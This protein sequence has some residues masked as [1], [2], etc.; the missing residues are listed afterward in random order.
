LTRKLFL[1]CVFFLLQFSYASAWLFISEVFPNTT[2]DKNLEYIEII[3]TWEEDVD[4]SWYYLQDKSEKKYVFPDEEV[5]K[6][7]E[8]KQ[9]IRPDTKLILNNSNEEIFLYDADEELV[10]E[11]SYTSSVKWEVIINEDIPETVEVPDEEIDQDIPMVWDDITPFLSWIIDSE[12][13]EYQEEILKVEFPAVEWS[14]Q[15]PTYLENKDEQLYFY[16][17]E[18]DRDECKVNLDFRNSFPDDVKESDYRCE[19]DFGFESDESDKCNPNTVTFPEWTFDIKIK[20]YD[21]NTE[22]FVAD[23]GFI[24]ENINK[25]TLFPVIEGDVTESQRELWNQYLEESEQEEFVINEDAM[26]WQEEF[27]WESDIAQEYLAPEIKISLQRPSYVAENLWLYTC[28]ISREECKINFDFRESFSDEL[29]ERDYACK[30]SFWFETDQGNRCNPNTITFPVWT[31]EVSIYIIHEDDKSVFS[32]KKILIQNDWYTDE[33]IPSSRSEV[34]S[35]WINPSVSVSSWVSKKYLAPATID[36]QSGLEYRD[37]KLYCTRD[38][39]R[40]NLKHEKSADYESCVWSFWKWAEYNNGTQNR[41]NPWYITY[42]KWEFKISLQVY[43]KDL[44]SNFRESRINFQSRDMLEESA[45]VWTLETVQDEPE[46]SDTEV[47]SAELKIILQGKISATKIVE[48]N[49]ITCLES[50]KCYIN[51][52]SEWGNNDWKY[53]WDF[54][55]GEVF[56]WKNPKWIWFWEWQYSVLLSQ[57]EI[58]QVFEILVSS[59]KIHTQPAWKDKKSQ[60]V[61]ILYDYSFL[62]IWDIF[63]N[64]KWNDIKEWFEIENRWTEKINLKWCYIDDVPDG[65][66]RAYKI[67]SDIFIEWNSSHRFYKVFTGL[68]LNNAWDTVS[69]ICNDTRI[70]SLSWDFKVWDNVSISHKYPKWKSI[71]HT[72]RLPELSLEDYWVFI[73]KTFKQNERLLKGGFKISGETLPGSQVRIILWNGMSDIYLTSDNDGLYEVLLKTWLKPWDATLQTQ[74]TDSAG[75]IFLFEGDKILE[76]TSAYIQSLIKVKKAKKAKKV[77]T[78]KPKTYLVSVA[79][80]SNESGII[81][82]NNYDI[83]LFL[84]VILW[85]LLSFFALSRRWVFF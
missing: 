17:C 3:N 47:T 27:S 59:E 6:S 4:I 69:L 76:I 22:K 20:I 64:P 16:A 66:S 29:P 26:E 11:F 79:N 23:S 83:L 33:I 8:K 52:T 48:G 5:L 28:D 30:T 13:T 34:A 85:F 71:Y 67:K 41:C 72:N 80:A 50:E 62:R 10:S 61:E 14:F 63:P 78:K 21:K 24:I 25:P 44:S 84:I 81:E 19:I 7:W 54:W 46:L 73:H 31:H 9:Y 74:V 1:I 18:D 15:R 58:K 75:D 37:G 57:W 2:D 45:Q 70:D 42:P 49:R 39:C 77:A 51:F 40:V 55:N 60:E 12:V 65:W 53:I 43:Q 35:W 38:Q 32:E 82:E 36:I 56:S 68:N